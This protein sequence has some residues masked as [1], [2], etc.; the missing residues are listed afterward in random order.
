ML[1][2]CRTPGAS[3]VQS[4]LGGATEV[5]AKSELAVASA[6]SAIKERRFE[7]AVLLVGDL[8]SP[9]LEVERQ[10]IA[11][12]NIRLRQRESIAQQFE[13]RRRSLCDD[14]FDDVETKQDVGIV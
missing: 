14:H 2:L 5:S 13:T 6:V 7:I 8:K 4:A 10:S 12:I 9:L 1:I 3:W 11:S